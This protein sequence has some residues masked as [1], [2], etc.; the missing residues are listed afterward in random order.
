MHI[1]RVHVKPMCV[2]VIYVLF[3]FFFS[4]HLSVSLALILPL[5]VSLLSLLG[6]AANQ[7]QG[8]SDHTQH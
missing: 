1:V 4:S 7:V 3:F 8:G 5:L 2:G 6:R